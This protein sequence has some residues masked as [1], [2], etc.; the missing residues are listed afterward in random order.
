[1]TNNSKL[2]RVNASIRTAGASLII[3]ILA[4]GVVDSRPSL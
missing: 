3:A 1:M 2:N 4:V